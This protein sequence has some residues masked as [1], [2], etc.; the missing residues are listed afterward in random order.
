M[1]VVIPLSCVFTHTDCI[2]QKKIR[3]HSSNWLR[4]A[5]GS[6]SFYSFNLPRRGDVKEKSVKSVLFVGDKIFSNKP[7]GNNCFLDTERIV[8]FAFV[9][10]ES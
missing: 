8:V 4:R 1:T 2:H 7:D 9:K 5:E 6:C 3:V 10:V